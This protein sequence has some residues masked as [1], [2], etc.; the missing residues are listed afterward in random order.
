MMSET[1]R[2]GPAAFWGRLAKVY[3]ASFVQ[4]VI[5]RPV[6]DLVIDELRALGPSRIADVGCGTGQMAAR[7]ATELRPREMYGIDL[8]EEM[9][10]QARARSNDVTWMHG[11]AE[12]LPLDDGSVDV[13]TS[14]EA[15]HWFRQGAALTD[16]H[17]VLT[18]GGHVVIG[19]L[20][21]FLRTAGLVADIFASG[22]GGGHFP[23]WREME[24]L[25]SEAGFR[26]VRR[27]R[28]R[29]PIVGRLPPHYVTVAQRDS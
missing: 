18:P 19:V 24:T 17:R 21:P 28:V 23:R 26:L 3:D 10:E 25:L 12:Q 13:I 5:Y 14:T 4:D 15:F 16:F 7:I 29:R 2:P 1:P 11:P 20:N 8:S 27:T 6:Q 9:L 22:A